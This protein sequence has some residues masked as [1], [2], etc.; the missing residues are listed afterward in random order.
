MQSYTLKTVLLI[1][2]FTL[3]RHDSPY[4]QARWI[5]IAGARLLITAVTPISSNGRCQQDG[6]VL[7]V[8]CGFY[9]SV[10]LD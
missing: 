2:L 7:D 9:S 6:R 8:I 4:V 1:S 3:L 10:L 5:L